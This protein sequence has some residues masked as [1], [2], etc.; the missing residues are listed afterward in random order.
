MFQYTFNNHF[1]YAYRGKDYF[2][3]KTK[4]DDVFLAEYT[5]PVTK[6]LVSWRESNLLAARLIYERK[7]GEINILLSG[8]MDSEVC[9]R[10]FAEQKLNFRAVSLLLKGCEETDDMKQIEQLKSE[11]S[12]KHEYVFL[13]PIQFLES[14]TFIET[15]DLVKCVSPI[16]GSHLWLANQ[17]GGTPIIAQ[18]EVHL[19]KE[20]NDDYVPGISPYVDSPWYILESERRFSI[21]LNF[22]KKNIPGVPGFFQ[23]LPEQVHTFLV[24]NEYLKKLI[25]NSISGKLGTRSSKNIIIKQFYPNLQDREK[26]HGWEKIIDIHDHYRSFFG[27]RFKNFN[28][29]YRM[30]L[31]KTILTLR[32]NAF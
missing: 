20:V 22:I 2:A 19:R 14:K 32:G 27:E 29:L 31:D 25:T 24:Y 9:L 23:Y 1:K 6:D 17:V 12:F 8:G 10:S 3:E 30:P 21:Y 5:Q 7:I 13:E 16:I 4:E 11:F 28:N 26:K 15:M 18:G